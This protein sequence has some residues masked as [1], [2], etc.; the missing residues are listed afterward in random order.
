MKKEL[1]IQ[2][3]IKEKKSILTIAIFVILIVYFA[4]LIIPTIWAVYSSLNNI[5]AY[6]NFYVHHLAFPTKLT[7]QNYKVALTQ[8]YFTASSSGIQYSFLDMIGFSLVYTIGSAFFYTL[9]PCVVAYAAARFK[10]K[11][12]MILYAFVIVTMSL[13]IVGTM[14]SELRMLKMLGIYDT[15]FG[16][17]VLRMNFLSINF[18]I[19]YAQFQMIPMAYS[20][21]AK[22]DGA[23]NFRIMTTVILPQAIPTIITIFLLSFITFWNDYQIPRLYMPSYPTVSEGL[24][25]FALTGEKAFNYIP[26]KLAG[27][28]GLTVPI[29]TIFALLNKYLRLNVAAGGIKG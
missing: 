19:F 4:S 11:F 23:S 3:K 15:F 7:L 20:E 18:L 9:T 14:P 28:I 21:A 13:P 17:F 26:I 25:T 27:F 29:V 5:A 2:P 8:F 10:F 1:L 12:S 24:F 22:V 6:R 16:M